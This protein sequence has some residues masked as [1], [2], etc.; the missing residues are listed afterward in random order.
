MELP[1]GFRFHPTD[2]ELVVHYLANQAAG[3]PC[4]APGVVAEANIYACDPWELLIPATDADAA[5]RYFFSPRERKYPNGARPNRAAGGGYW[6]ATG[7]DKPVLSSSET[8]NQRVV[9][10]K[11]ALVFYSGRP[12]RGVKTGWIMHEYRLVTGGGE[13]AGNSATS[14]SRGPSSSSTTSMRLDEWVL[15]RIYKKSNFSSS[16]LQHLIISDQEQEEASSTVE[17]QDSR[18]NNI[19]AAAAT[20]AFSHKSEALDHDGHQFRQSQSQ[21]RPTMTKSCSLTDLLNTIDG[22]ALSQMLLLDEDDGGPEEVDAHDAEPL[23]Y[24]P[25]RTTA[26]THPQSLINY[27]NNNVVMNGGSSSHFIS[28]NLLPPRAV[29]AACSD[30]NGLMLKR[31][32][33]MT[34]MD[35]AAGSSSLDDDGSSKRLKLL[36]TARQGSY[37][38]QL[39]VDTNNAAGFQFQFQ[40]QSLPPDAVVASQESFYKQHPVETLTGRA[41]GFCDL[42]YPEFLLSTH[43]VEHFIPEHLSCNSQANI[44]SYSA[45]TSECMRCASSEQHMHGATRRPLNSR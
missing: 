41:L 22:S 10:V 4:P 11:K 2:E 15:C 18:G 21:T 39:L 33:T 9:G 44:A 5:E 28:N 1:A 45:A 7:T 13:A 17:Q 31:K 8:T 24:Y 23:I 25:E 14:S 35:G 26:H 38:S 40:F 37:C 32:R 27:N 29:D 6:K 34:A 12:P 43:Y 19:N 36:P 3:F 42:N 20:L 16:S 30:N